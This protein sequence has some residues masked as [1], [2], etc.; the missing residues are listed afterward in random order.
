MD[1]IKELA[2]V[3]SKKKPSE[4]DKYLPKNSKIRKLY[5]LVIIKGVK[6]D[7]EAAQLIY[8]SNKSDKKYLMLKR[9][10]VQKL[11]E[12]VFILDYAEAFEEN[13]AN[14]QFTV[15]KE[16][17]IA[18]KLLL[19]NVYH[20][21]TKTITKVEQTAEKYYLIDLQ[22]IAAKKLRS[23]YSLKGFPVETYQ[24]D[25]K[26]KILSKYRRYYNESR[27]M[28]EILYAKTK[29]TV[30]KIPEFVFEASRYTET[31]VHWIE[32]YDSPFLKLYLYRIN[33]IKY[34]QLNEFDKVLE[35]INKLKGLVEDFNFIKS[36]GILLE[37]N[38]AYALYYR[39]I[40][41]LE[42]AEQYLKICMEYCDY[43]AF[44]KFLIQQLNFDVKIKQ[45][46]Y[47]E[48]GKILHEVYNVSQYQF[49]ESYDKSAWAIREAYLYF[50]YVATDQVELFKYIRSYKDGF[51]LNSFL[52]KTKKSSKDKYG[53]NIMLLII[54][55]QLLAMK[56]FIEIDYE[57][58]NLLIYYY[59]YLK[60]LN[61]IRTIIFF[62]A[63]GKVAA[64][65]FD[66]LEMN[67]REQKML[68]KYNEMGQKSYDIIE[69]IP[70]EKF[71]QLITSYLK[72]IKQSI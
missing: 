9:N 60:T 47:E 30:A 59:R 42:K 35:N 43:R 44:N 17:N 13:Y 48:A 16:L 34:N 51:N 15:E 70:Y 22:V 25:E 20:N 67:E 24:Y 50:I 18:E 37:I 26:V 10:L 38:Y 58:S 55:L 1:L 46:Q 19:E 27:G 52:G 45:E 72:Q 65:G 3:L 2:F 69:L 11:S 23:V 36:K 7:D 68:N 41:Q 54:R 29:Y 5:D 49:L 71:W 62:K 40:R 6:S 31:I 57:G 21:P 61:C 63:L 32:E 4:F 12:L 39:N 64:R 28:W 53:Y 56:N 14:I 8:K 33:L 66:R